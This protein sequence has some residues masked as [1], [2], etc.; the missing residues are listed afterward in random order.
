VTLG[1][2]LKAV[3]LSDF[4]SAVEPLVDLCGSAA[5]QRVCL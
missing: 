2:I 1:L 4:L 5:L 3:G